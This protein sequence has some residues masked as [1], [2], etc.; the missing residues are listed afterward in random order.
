[1]ADRKTS[2]YT[3]RD[4]NKI[5]KFGITE[6]PQRR[7]AEN[8]RAGLGKKMRVEGPVVTEESARAWEEKKIDNYTEREGRPR[9]GNKQ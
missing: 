1:M 2:R 8:V 6:D 9:P 5:I 3:M 7:E 4:G